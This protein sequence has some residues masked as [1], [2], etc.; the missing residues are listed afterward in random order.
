[1][2]IV[3]YPRL[4]FY[5]GGGEDRASIEYKGPWDEAKINQAVTM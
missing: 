2:G 5:L 1:M 3:T 4:F